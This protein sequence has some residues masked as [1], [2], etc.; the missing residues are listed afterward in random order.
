MGKEIDLWLTIQ[1]QKGMFKTEV[2]KKLK[3]IRY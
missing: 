3:M 2:Q 1:D